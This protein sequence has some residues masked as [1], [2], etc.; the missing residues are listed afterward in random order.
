VSRTKFTDAA[1]QLAR[2]NGVALLDANGLSRLDLM[3]D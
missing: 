2:S 1:V 3:F